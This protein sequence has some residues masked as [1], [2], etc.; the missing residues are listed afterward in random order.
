MLTS[1]LHLGQQAEQPE[2]ES[3]SASAGQLAIE[4]SAKRDTKAADETKMR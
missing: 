4:A 1:S 2:S 3:Y